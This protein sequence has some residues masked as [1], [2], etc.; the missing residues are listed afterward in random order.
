MLPI[1]PI[2]KLNSVQS[3]ERWKVH[4]AGTWIQTGATL[5]LRHLF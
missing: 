1:L 5:G 2:Q 3:P 4:L